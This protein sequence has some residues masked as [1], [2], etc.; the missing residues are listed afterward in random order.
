M[1]QIEIEKMLE[2]IL[3]PKHDGKFLIQESITCVVE[4]QKGA[5]YLWI[6]DRRGKNALA[7]IF[8]IEETENGVKYFSDKYEYIECKTIP[9]VF[10]IVKN[11]KY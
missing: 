3:W 6:G 9:E 4:E 7:W 5:L 2:E 11:R 1:T 10:E 8:N